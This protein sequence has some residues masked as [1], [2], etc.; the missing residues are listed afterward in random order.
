MTNLKKEI[1]DYFNKPADGKVLVSTI[2]EGFEPN[3]A[4]IVR[5][6]AVGKSWL[7]QEVFFDA[8]MQ[9]LGAK[10][11][12][13]GVGLSEE[14]PDTGAIHRY[15]IIDGQVYKFRGDW[16]DQEPAKEFVY[17]LATGSE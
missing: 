12:S 9:Y 3:K 17:R 13:W 15:L 6:N 8:L 16:Y 5:A 10:Q 7:N 11:V 1:S 4:Q 2:Q 14:D